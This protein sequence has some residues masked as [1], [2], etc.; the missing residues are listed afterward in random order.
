MIFAAVAALVASAVLLGAY[1][2]YAAWVT[3]VVLAPIGALASVLAE[4]MSAHDAPL[5]GLRRQFA[6]LAAATAA[7]LLVA[8]T[9]LVW[10]MFVSGHDAAFTMIAVLYSGAVLLWAGRHVLDSMV[11]RLNREERMRRML[12]AAV[13]HDLRTP[14]TS[15]RLLAD[16]IGDDIGEPREYARRMGTHVNAL[17]TLVDDLFELTRLQSGELRWTAESIQLDD[18]LHET[19]DALRPVAAPR[20]VTVDGIHGGAVHGSPERLQRVLFNLIQNAIHHTPTDGSVTVRTERNGDG[21]DIEVA[22]TGPGIPREHRDRVF[23]PFYRGD[24]ARSGD[25]GSGL[26]LAISQAIVEAHGGRIWIE[27]APV[28]TKVRF[29]L[30][31]P[32]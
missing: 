14:L 23:E 27:D 22:D 26:G 7:L 3:F 20:V 13:S 30:P 29:H 19:V 25:G 9:V 2:W 17:G 18:L 5:D 8:V 10:L 6:W 32:A 24:A 4:R 28:G 15:L 12:Y 11:A 1:G 16:A 21:I 31:T